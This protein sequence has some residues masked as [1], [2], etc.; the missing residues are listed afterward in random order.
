M[1]ARRAIRSAR[2][3]AVALA[4]ARAQ[5]DA[6]KRALGERGPVWWTD[7]AL[8]ITSGWSTIRRMPNGFPHSVR[9]ETLIQS[10]WLHN[11]CYRFLASFI[12]RVIAFPCPPRGAVTYSQDRS[13]T[14]RHTSLRSSP[15][16]P[17]RSFE[18]GGPPHTP[19]ALAQCLRSMQRMRAG[20]EVIKSLAG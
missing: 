10:L 13:V 9:A 4:R 7:G 18:P 3:D 8:T 5:V 2:G 16:E 12:P 20:C 17:S 19:G 15:L 11:V 14:I 6:A 1:A